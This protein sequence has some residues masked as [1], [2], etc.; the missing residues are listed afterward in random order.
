M[1]INFNKFNENKEQPNRW[2]TVKQTQLDYWEKVITDQ[3]ARKILGSVILKNGRC[4]T[5]QYNILK[6]A[7]QGDITPSLFHSKN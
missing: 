1:I 3:Y 6:M 4:S 5:R 2:F 7:V